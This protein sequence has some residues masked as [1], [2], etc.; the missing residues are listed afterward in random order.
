MAPLSGSM[1]DRDLANLI[2][3]KIKGIPIPERYNDSDCTAIVKRYW[4]R[5]MESETFIE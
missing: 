5:A 1:V 2:W 4:H 3:L